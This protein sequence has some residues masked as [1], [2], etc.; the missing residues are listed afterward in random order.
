MVTR[1]I[2]A[3]DDD[4]NFLDHLRVR[5]EDLGLLGDFEYRPIVARGQ[6]ASDVSRHCANEIDK[7]I[8]ENLEIALALIDIVIIEHSEELPS[9]RSG[10][11]VAK[12]LSSYVP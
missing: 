8:G 2:V 5:L 4:V 12:Y 10:L 7:I 1:A 6:T 9:D 11:E 3:I